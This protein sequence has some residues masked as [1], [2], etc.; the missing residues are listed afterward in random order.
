M[1]KALTDKEIKKIKEVSNTC[2]AGYSYPYVAKFILQSETKVDIIYVDKATR[3]V[4]D[5]TV[6][7]TSP[8]RNLINDGIGFSHSIL[9]QIKRILEEDN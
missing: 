5:H 4:F 3:L 7:T 9:E 6:Y 1:A 2:F 8:T